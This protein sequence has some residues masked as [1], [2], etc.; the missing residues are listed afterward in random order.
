[1][2]GARFR[3]LD[4]GRLIDDELELVEPSEAF[5]DALLRG[6]EQAR[7]LDPSVPASSHEMQ[8]RW[9][10]ENPRGRFCPLPGDWRVP[11]YTFWMMHRGLAMPTVV[12]GLGLRVGHTRDTVMYFGHLGYHVHAPWRGRH[13][14]ERACRLV[15]PLARR[16]GMK[17]LWITCNPDNVASRR[18]CERL[19]AVWVEVVDVPPGNV[20]HSRGEVRK[21]RYR[22]DL[23]GG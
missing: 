19:G 11:Q 20:L 15:L 8:R 4:P 5:I 17:E 7:Q 23:Q 2:F 9:L 1:M 3:F 6:L 14:A 10:E 22:L 13:L 12:G 16:H 18:T 21:Y